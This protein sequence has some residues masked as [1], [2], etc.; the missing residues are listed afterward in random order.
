MNLE[1]T[2]NQRFNFIDSYVLSR[3]YG[4]YSGVYDAEHRL[5]FPNST[6]T[7]CR[8]EQLPNSTG[9]LPNDRTH[10]FKFIGSYAFDFGLSIGSF[11]SW[12]TGTP[13]NEF[14]GSVWGTP[15]HTFLVKRG[16]AGRTPS[17]WDLNFRFSYNLNKAIRSFG[18]QRLILDIFH[19]ASQRDVV[20]IEQRHYLI[21]DSEGNQL[22][23]N[24]TYL[25]PYKFQPPMT[26]RLGFE[27]G[28]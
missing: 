20:D 28:F 5:E 14:G 3:N 12:Q 13:L 18:Y 27:V 17:I 11:F 19:L 25:E 23:E 1:R 8:V 16:T 9:L 24:A 6:R 7:L 2:G 10:S 26:V 4:N 21:A 22:S 15:F